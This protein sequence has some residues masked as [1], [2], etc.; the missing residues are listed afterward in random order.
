MH[1]AVLCSVHNPTESPQGLLPASVLGMG[2][3][4]GSGWKGVRGEIVGGEKKPTI[5]FNTQFV[6][7]FVCF[8]YK[9]K[10]RDVGLVFFP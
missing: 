4:H 8:K 5:M 6:C 9:V 2:S 10:S 7:L 3:E 1:A